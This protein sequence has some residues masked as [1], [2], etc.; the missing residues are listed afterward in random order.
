[1]AIL[2]I[3]DTDSRTGGM[4]TTWIG[5]EVVRRLAAGTVDAAYLIRLHP[6][7]PHKTRGNGAVAIAT[8]SDRGFD[9]A[10]EVVA[11]HAVTGDPETNPGVVSLEEANAP[12]ALL[13]FARDAI[14]TRV[15]QGDARSV[16]D[17][18]DASMSTW[19]NGRGLIGATGAIGAALAHR[20][21]E[22][23]NG[24]FADWT[25]EH[26]A[27]RSAG[28]WGAPRDVELPDELPA[29]PA[30]WDTVDP[31]TGA[32]VCVPRSPCPVLCG[33]RGDDPAAVGAVIDN[34][35]GEPT[36]RD[37]LFITNQGTDAHRR[38]GH[39]GDLT[40]THTYRV[41]G[42]VVSP[43]RTAEGGHVT[44]ELGKEATSCDCIAFAP[45]GRFREAVRGLAV[46]DSIVACGE[47]GDGTLKL[48]KFALVGRRLT[49]NAT[50]TCPGCGRSME[51]AGRDQGYRCRSCDT[52]AP[53]KAKVNVTRRL[54]PGWYE[55]PP[56]AR[57]HLAQPLVRGQ[58]DF[59]V[60]PTS[61]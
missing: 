49:T 51:S 34:T 26:I 48:E 28:R 58:Y 14:R 32:P 50:P 60:H 43:P 39:V 54:Q 12:A 2:G 22:P 33:I 52:T 8:T 38:P 11:D 3:D 30:V 21:D 44:F 4:C 46:G 9:I 61:R 37:Q 25:Y 47:V 45:T 13:T 18:V 23:G 35:G 55:V 16:L 41:R 53:G 56:D 7:I 57:R 17:T 19:G 10:T 5:S 20:W 24:A 40:D 59:P 36:A 6:A 29:G 42:E 31:A 27:Y 1:M 15:T